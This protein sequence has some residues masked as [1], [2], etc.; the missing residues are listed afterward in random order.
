LAGFL[1]E[2][3][4]ALRVFVKCSFYVF[5]YGEMKEILRAYSINKPSIGTNELNTKDNQG[6]YFIRE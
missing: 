5:F 1:I 2:I 3:F 4:P 6:K